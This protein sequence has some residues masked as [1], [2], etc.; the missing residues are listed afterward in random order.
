MRNRFEIHNDSVLDKI[1]GVYQPLDSLEHFLE[2]DINNQGKNPKLS[3]NPM[4]LRFKVYYEN[5]SI[6][7]LPNTLDKLTSF[8]EKITN[9]RGLLILFYK[10]LPPPPVHLDQ[11]TLMK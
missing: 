4:R 6:D 3:D 11:P 5:H 2:R 9:K 1:N 10:P 7:S 8:Y